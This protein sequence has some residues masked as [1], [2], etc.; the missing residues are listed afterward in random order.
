MIGVVRLMTAVVAVM[1][2]DVS[3][4][5]IVA[6]VRQHFFAAVMV[7]VSHARTAE[8]AVN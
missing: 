8:D 4:F 3:R 2:I 5:R 6:V 1:A 7:F